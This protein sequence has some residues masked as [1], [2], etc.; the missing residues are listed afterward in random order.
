MDYKKLLLI[1]FFIPLSLFSAQRDKEVTYRLKL[2]PGVKQRYPN[3]TVADIS[4]NDLNNVTVTNPAIG[5]C[6]RFRTTTTLTNQTCGGGS[7]GSVVGIASSQLAVFQIPTLADTT[8]TA[9]TAD[10]PVF[11]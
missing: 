8:L 10:V 11:S 1:L 4:I 2:A 5:Q 7:G 3:A 6:L 9:S